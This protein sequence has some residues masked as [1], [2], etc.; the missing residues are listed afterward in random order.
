MPNLDPLYRTNPVLDRVS[1][2]E[3]IKNIL[4]T[5]AWSWA[6]ANSTEGQHKPAQPAR[7][8]IVY[9]IVGAQPRLGRSILVSYAVDFQVQD[10]RVKCLGLSGI[11]FR[12]SVCVRPRLRQNTPL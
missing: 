3:H 12:F 11:A 7:H 4:L 1:L 10:Y 2:C 6:V 5:H 8:F 9:C